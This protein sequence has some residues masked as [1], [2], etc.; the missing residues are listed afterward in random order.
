[1]GHQFKW[2]VKWDFDGAITHIVIKSLIALQRKSGLTFLVVKVN[3]I[4]W[5]SLN[6][7]I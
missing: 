4:Q 3:F 7:S 5:E 1:M 2:S 6:Y